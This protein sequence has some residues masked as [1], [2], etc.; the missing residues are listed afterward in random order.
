[1]TTLRE[2]GRPVRVGLISAGEPVE[3]ADHLRRSSILSETSVPAI[4]AAAAAVLQ[5]VDT[6]A[7]HW[8]GF[9]VCVGTD[10]LDGARYLAGLRWLLDAGV[11]A[12]VCTCP[13]LDSELRVVGA[14]QQ[15]RTLGVPVI[16]AESDG[17]IDQGKWEHGVI[18]ACADHSLSSDEAVWDV[19]PERCRV[20]G[21]RLSNAAAAGVVAG[22]AVAELA[23]S[24]PR[25]ELLDSLRAWT[26]SPPSR[27]AS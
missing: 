9:N 27:L 3:Y 12:I 19:E 6:R 20:G 16:V 4:D 22:V 1:M 23:R 18:M 10:V 5:A 2:L 25:G 15:A 24:L 8:I 26:L 11:D 13:V 21:A 14:N 7:E 17:H